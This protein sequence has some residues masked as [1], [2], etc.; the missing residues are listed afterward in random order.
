MYLFPMNTSPLLISSLADFGFTEENFKEV[1]TLCF[2]CI[3]VLVSCIRALHY[4]RWSYVETRLYK[5]QATS[6]CK[7][8]VCITAQSLNAENLY[9]R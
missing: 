5:K 7:V 3:P 4:F 6:D 9:F 2:T 1:E 8:I